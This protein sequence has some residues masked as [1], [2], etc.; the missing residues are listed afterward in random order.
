MHATHNNRLGLNM[1]LDIDF[2]SIE[3]ILSN[4][5]DQGRDFSFESEV[6]EFL[7]KSGAETFPPGRLAC[8]LSGPDR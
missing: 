7:V 6:Y 3:Q 5:W 1:V 4:A 8:V 2:D